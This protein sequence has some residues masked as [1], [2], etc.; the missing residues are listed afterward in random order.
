MISTQSSNHFNLLLSWKV[1]KQDLVISA[2]WLIVGVGANGNDILCIWH[3]LHVISGVCVC[4]KEI[5]L[6]KCTYG[7]RV[8]IKC[9]KHLQTFYSHSTFLNIV[10]WNEATFTKISGLYIMQWCL[11]EWCPIKMID[12][13]WLFKAIAHGR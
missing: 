1:K 8:N 7:E 12:K 10:I 5:M 2:E 6:Y 9:L 13:I 3:I 4:R 11:Y